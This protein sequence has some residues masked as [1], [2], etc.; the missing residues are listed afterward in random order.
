MM[1]RVRK[2]MLDY[3]DRQTGIKAEEVKH[4]IY[5]FK[6]KIEQDSKAV[7]KIISK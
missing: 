3:Q 4:Q 1:A 5:Q 7:L 6:K 2:R